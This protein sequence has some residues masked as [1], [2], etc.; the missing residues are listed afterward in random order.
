MKAEH[1]GREIVLL[2]FSAEILFLAFLKL[3][4]CKLT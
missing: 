1:M 3:T 4:F 2:H